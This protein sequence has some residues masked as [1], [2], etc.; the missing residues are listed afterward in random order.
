MRWHQL[1]SSAAHVGCD[2]DACIVRTLSCGR[3][4]SRDWW[5]VTYRG[6][7]QSKNQPH[8]LFMHINTTH[9]PLVC[10]S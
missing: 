9:P 5:R 2:V 7:R 1:E 6:H 10:G 4:C 8:I 3:G